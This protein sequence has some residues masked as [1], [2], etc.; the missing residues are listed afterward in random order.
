MKLC[1]DDDLIEL[2]K[3]QPEQRMMV[4]DLS[5]KLGIDIKKNPAF[6]DWIFRINKKRKEKNLP[7]IKNHG[8]RAAN[9]FYYLEEVK[10]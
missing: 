1:T 4:T 5:E 9:A 3:S 6:R 7:L 10:K 2:F 8:R